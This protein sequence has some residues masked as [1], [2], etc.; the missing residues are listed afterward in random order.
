MT[1]PSE[2]ETNHSSDLSQN[3]SSVP[4]RAVIFDLDNTLFDFIAMKEKA[5]EAAAS[6]MI[7]AGLPLT[8]EEVSRRIFQ[9]YKMEGIEF[10]QVFDTMLID[11]L[12]RVDSKILASGVVAYRR[13]REAMLVS[14]PHT[15][16]TLIALVKRGIKIAVVSDAPSIQ[17]WLRLCYLQLQ[18]LFDTVVTFDDTGKR[19]P[20]PQP[21]QLA[22]D[23]M[24]IEAEE[25]LMI[26]DWIDR[27]LLG[28]KSLG[29]R[30]AHAR[31]GAE[32]AENKPDPLADEVLDDIRDILK[33]VDRWR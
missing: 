2:H 17:A 27:D 19:K 28:A 13:V 31:Y 10:Q 15:T 24:E 6:A 14:Y 11:V 5:I 16:S 12:G 22:L 32:I 4:L 26:G 20:S 33:L 30:T 3:E 7:D 18:D 8:P 1:L 21:F 23:R 29:M 9:V 25:A